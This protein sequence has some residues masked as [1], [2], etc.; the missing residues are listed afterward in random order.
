MGFKISIILLCLIGAGMLN[1]N[2][3]Y[4]KW[5]CVIACIIAILL[6]GLRHIHVGMDTYNY[7]EMFERV[8][9]N[10][11]NYILDGFLPS[12][13]F[14][15]T[16]N[17]LLFIMKCFQ[18]LSGNF[19]LF[20]IAF[21]VFVNVPIFKMIYEESKHIFVSI[22]VYMGVYFA[23]LST[24]GLRQTVSIMIMCIYGLNFLRGKKFIK[25][26][27]CVFVAFLFHKSSIVFIP[28]YFLSK[29]KVTPRSILV[30]VTVIF[31]FIIERVYLAQ[32][33]F[34][35]QGWYE[36]YTDQYATAGPR[37]FALLSVA[38]LVLTFMYHRIIECNCKDALLLENSA[39]MA[40]IMLPFAF[41]DPSLLRG[42]F[43]FSI[44][45]IILIPEIIDANAG[46]SRELML[47]AVTMGL[48]F[49]ILTS[50]T[51][52][53]F[54]WEPGIYSDIISPV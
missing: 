45:S 7:W 53:K 9:D 34:S 27:L 17:G 6:S 42:V 13:F 10:S 36:S 52:Y 30:S 54:M 24:T 26:M 43:Y 16:E 37:T 32:L 25:F 47:T 12:E 14:I 4:D 50:S 29:R 41:V 44:Y 21:A 1:K 19:R 40:C 20:L 31:V 2:R 15:R 18:V 46:K 23:F 39:I 49:L 28:F 11:W 35:F 5:F 3:Q 38:I 48:I 8:K 51:P 22:L 33:L